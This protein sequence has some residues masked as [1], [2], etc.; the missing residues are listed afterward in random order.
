VLWI[1]AAVVH[2]AAAAVSAVVSFPPPPPPPVADAPPRT[3]SAY[4][5]AFVGRGAGASR[6][7]D[8]GGFARSCRNG[9]AAAVVVVVVAPAAPGSFDGV[10]TTAHFRTA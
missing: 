5:I 9:V 7:R 2:A 1:G 8:A 4:A 10:K 6:V 3:M